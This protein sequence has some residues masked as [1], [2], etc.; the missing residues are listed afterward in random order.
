[1]TSQK[2]KEFTK[3]L[4]VSL[5]VYIPGLFTASSKIFRLVVPEPGHKNAWSVAE[6]PKESVTVPVYLPVALLG[7]VLEPVIVG[8]SKA[9]KL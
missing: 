4:I 7:H 6:Q 8:P 9:S 1:M 3:E 2:A 5:L